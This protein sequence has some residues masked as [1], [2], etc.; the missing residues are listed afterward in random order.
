MNEDKL[1]IYRDKVSKLFTKKQVQ[2]FK[3]M[4]CTHS[5]FVKQMAYKGLKLSLENPDK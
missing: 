1:K 3:N 4:E 5:V 2:M